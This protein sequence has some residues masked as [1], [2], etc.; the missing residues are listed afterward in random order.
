MTA[1]G[2]CLGGASSGNSG[3][4]G[5]SGNGGNGSTPGP[6][7]TLGEWSLDINAPSPVVERITGE[8][9]T[10]PEYDENEVAS[11]IER[12][13]LGSMKNDPATEWFSDKFTEQVGI[14]T[15]PVTVPSTNAVSKM[16]TLLSAG[17]KNPVLMQIS[18][19][20]F[21]DFVAEGWLEPVDELWDD[22][23]YGLFPPYFKD[24]LTTG[25]DPSLEGEHTYIGVA[26]SE[27]HWFNY[28][29]KVLKELGFEGDFLEESTWEDVREVCEEAS[30]HSEDYF[31]FAWWGKGNRYPIYPWLLMT[32]S[33]G[34]S[35]VQDDGTVVVNSDEA[36]A[37][38]EWQRTLI[39]EELVPNVAQYGEGGLADLFLSG[40]LA[41]YVGKPGMMQ[42][43]YEEWGDDTDKYDVALPPKSAGNERVS[44]MNTDFLAVN[45]AAP[46]EAKRAAMVYMDGSRSAVASAQEYD[47]EGNYPANKEAWNTEILA[48]ARHGEKARRNAEIAKV[49]LWPKQIQTYDALISQLQ[50]VWLQDKTAQAALDEAQSKIDG[51]L[52]QN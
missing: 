34:G 41:G 1:I 39:D 18:Q 43:A 20:F 33:R 36:V 52:E 38:L 45:R 22:S 28:S 7:G 16:R 9:W 31:G 42:L 48:D 46:P 27:A 26:L 14:E 44:Y 25:I 6:A 5:S 51:I 47:M 50:S 49:E 17:S 19:E 40:K 30:S 3:N 12:M 23:A 32:W 4:G 29:P 2:G 13:N 24:Q 21:M 11:S 37:A 8:E 15:T 10:P 35:F